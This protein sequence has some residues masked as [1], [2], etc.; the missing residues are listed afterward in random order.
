VDRSLRYEILVN[1]ICMACDLPAEERLDL[2]AM[3]SLIERG[4][5]IRERIE[6]LLR[7]GS[8]RSESGDPPREAGPHN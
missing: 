2:L 6:R 4:R 5:A 8:G 7:R 3:D 1:T